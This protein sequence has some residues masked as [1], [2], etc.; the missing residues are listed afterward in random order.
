MIREPYDGII[1][2]APTGALPLGRVA[3]IRGSL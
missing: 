2:D 3:T 1:G